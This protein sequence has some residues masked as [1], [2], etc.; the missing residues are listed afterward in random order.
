MTTKFSLKLLDDHKFHPNVLHSKSYQVQAL[1][2]DGEIFR[3]GPIISTSV[4]SC[5]GA[6]VLVGMYALEYWST[7][8]IKE[9]WEFLKETNLEGRKGGHQRAFGIFTVGQFLFFG[10]ESHQEQAWMKAV[11]YDIIGTYQSASEP[12]HLTYIYNIRFMD[13]K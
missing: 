8:L 13:V 3:Q 12:G 5:C 1:R 10:N 2:E 4:G 6:V 9:M 11:P 7:S